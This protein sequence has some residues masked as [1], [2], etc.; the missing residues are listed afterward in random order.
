MGEKGP[1][2]SGT[3][4]SE[5]RLLER[6]RRRLAK[7][8]DEMSKIFLYELL[9]NLVKVVFF[10]AFLIRRA[11]SSSLAEPSHRLTSPTACSFYTAV[12]ADVF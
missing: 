10:E 4:G 11:H 3:A 7:I 6:R 8:I 5:L 2:C 1:A 9:L 12:L